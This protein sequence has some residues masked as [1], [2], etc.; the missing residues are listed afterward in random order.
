VHITDRENA[1]PARFKIWIDGNT[2][3]IIE[4][5]AQPFERLRL[6]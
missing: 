2:A 6:S 1:L 4:P 3:I 5:D